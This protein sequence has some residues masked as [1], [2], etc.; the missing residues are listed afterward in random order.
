MSLLKAIFNKEDFFSKKNVFY[1]NTSEALFSS[2]MV[3]G[4]VE[5]IQHSSN[6]AF[7]IAGISAIAYGGVNALLC[8]AFASTNKLAD[9][10]KEKAAYEKEKTNQ[11]IE[12]HQFR[13]WAIKL[14]ER[15]RIPSERH[16]EA[17]HKVQNMIDTCRKHENDPTWDEESFLFNSL[18][19][20]LGIDVQKKIDTD[21][22]KLFDEL[23]KY[24]KNIPPRDPG[25][26]Q[27]DTDG[28]APLS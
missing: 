28:P 1:N 18:A 7:T 25:A 27:P 12:D 9:Q 3:Y 4:G 15:Q 19:D 11:A 17:L 20:I 6:T 10:R 8:F 22:Q 26:G 14:L 16:E 24:L 5:V 23:E 21:S 2:G 13:E